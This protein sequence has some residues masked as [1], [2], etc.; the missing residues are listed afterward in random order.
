MTDDF[1]KDT[2][3]DASEPFSLM[4]LALIAGALLGASFDI[5]KTL[6]KL[7]GKNAV[8][9]FTADMLS[10][11]CA[12]LFLFVCALDLNDGILR[13]HHLLF[14]FL[15]LLF[16]KKTLSKAV[17]TLL[18]FVVY[19]FGVIAKT[20]SGIALYPIAL[21]KKYIIRLSKKLYTAISEHIKKKEFKNALKKHT[22]AS[23]IGFEVVPYIREENKKDGKKNRRRC[24][25]HRNSI[26]HN[27]RIWSANGAQR[28]S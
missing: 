27:R 26:S 12:Y 5:S 17:T 4:V 3:F 6:Q 21:A 25:T 1:F 14:A 11:I 22:A 8:F 28:A 15:G 19:A 7:I 24:N 23:A 9:V 18:G 13:W 16:Y 10:V 2:V 20:A